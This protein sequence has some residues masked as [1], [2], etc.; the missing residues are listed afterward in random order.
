MP[1]NCQS[2]ACSQAPCWCSLWCRHCTGLLAR[3]PVNCLFFTEI[4]THSSAR[5]R[6][7]TPLLCDRSSACPYISFV[8]TSRF[9]L[10]AARHRRGLGDPRRGPYELLTPLL[11]LS[12]SL[13]PRSRHFSPAVRPPQKYPSSNE[14]ARSYLLFVRWL[15][16]LV[17]V[18][19]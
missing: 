3:Y 18:V 19:P 17:R 2:L 7:C 5:D 13:S 16:P 12:S 8:L 9:P 1:D 14:I 11:N 6:L 15:V 10:L 4:A